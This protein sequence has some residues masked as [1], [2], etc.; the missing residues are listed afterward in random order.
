MPSSDLT[1]IS[2]NPEHSP[3]GQALAASAS[4]GFNVRANLIF[5]IAQVAVGV[6]AYAQAVVP[7]M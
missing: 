5:T 6:L 7:V 3:V 4:T 2:Q 1:Y